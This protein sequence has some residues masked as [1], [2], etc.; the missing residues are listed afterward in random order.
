MSKAVGVLAIVALATTFMAA[1][2]LP[3]AHPNQ[4]PPL[5]LPLPALSPADASGG[6]PTGTVSA[7]P[8]PL[9]LAEAITRGLRQNLAPLLAS[10]VSEQTRAQHLSQLAALLPSVE[11]SAGEVRQKINLAAFGFSFPGAPQIVGPFNVFQASA[12]AHVPLLNLSALDRTRAAASLQEAAQ[13]DYQSVRNLVVLA[14]ANQYL[15]SVAD[16]SRVQAAQAELTTAQRALQQ[17]EDMLSAGTV[18]KLSVVRAQVQRDQQQQQLT[19][20]Q[21][22]LAKQ[23]LS[24][25]RAIGLPLAQQFVLTSTTPFATLT[26]PA[27]AAA[28]AQA[29]AT[30]PDYRAAQQVV[31]SAQL[32]VASAKAGRLPT[33]SLDGNYGTIGHEL[34]SNHPIFAVGASINLP[35][36]SGGQIAAERIRAEAQLRDAE[37][38]AADLQAAIGVQVRSAL[39]DLE[40]QHQQVGVAQHAQQLAHQ[41]LTLAQDRFL[42]GVADNLEVVQAQQAVAVGDENYIA[43]L[44]GYNLAKATLAQALGVAATQFQRY[45][46]AH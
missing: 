1:Q 7:T 40:S 25:A 34:D 43:A 26:A 30:R 38:R 24:L 41:E 32:T 21:N 14:V 44:Y 10:D 37:A 17:A 39:L 42:A 11:A 9:S 20:Q 8:L 12:A 35:V 15:L 46:P 16:Q 31:R 45:L 28:V 3:P 18:D 33:V 27:P 23:R 29:L 36:F 22:A 5:Q 13:D 19:A 4:A 6:V 2:G